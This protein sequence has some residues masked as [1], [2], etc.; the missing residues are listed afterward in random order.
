M[1]PG[2]CTSAV[3]PSSLPISA[4]AIGLEMLIRPC[5]RSASSSP[6]IWYLTI[7]PESSSSSSTVAPN[8]TLPPAST[9]GRVDDLGGRELAF[10]FLDAAFDEALAILGGVVLGVLG[11][12]TLG[13]RLGDRVDHPGALDGLELVQLGLE[14]LGA[15]FGDG[16]GG[17]DDCSFVK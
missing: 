1:P 6:T 15:A 2:A 12:V 5:F 9:D 8:T 10:D 3:S 7:S 17:H 13:A 14:L 16:N 11:Q 4:R